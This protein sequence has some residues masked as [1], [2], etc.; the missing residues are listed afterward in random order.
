MLN[1]QKELKEFQLTGNRFMRN[2][3]VFKNSLVSND[4]ID[5]P[6]SP[7]VLGNNESDT[8]ITFI[9][10]PFCGHCKNAHKILEKIL[11]KNHDNLKWS[12]IS[13]DNLYDLTCSN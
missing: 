2:Y 11:V 6:N 10:N 7:I 5:L 4:R 12:G 8:E 1:N 9:T 13:V 3:E